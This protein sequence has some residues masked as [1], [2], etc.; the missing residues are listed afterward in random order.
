MGG[1][2]GIGRDDRQIVRILLLRFAPFIGP[3]V[4][5]GSLADIAECDGD[6]RYWHKADIAARTA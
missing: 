6:V 3:N 4:R 5:F 1:H 2:Q